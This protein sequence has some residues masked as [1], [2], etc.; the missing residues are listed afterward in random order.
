MV[1]KPQHSKQS[2]RILNFAKRPSIKMYIVPCSVF[3]E[4]FPYKIFKEYFIEVFTN[5]IL[6]YIKDF[7]KLNKMWI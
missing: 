1:Q 6:K 5:K 2:V 4:T 3:R 7:G